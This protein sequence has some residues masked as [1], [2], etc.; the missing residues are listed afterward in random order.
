MDF[1]DYVEDTV[2]VVLY[3]APAT[4]KK[5][6]TTKPFLHKNFFHLVANGVSQCVRI[7]LLRLIIVSS[8]VPR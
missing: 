7:E 5:V 6:V 2:A 1:T 4:K 8:G 3:A